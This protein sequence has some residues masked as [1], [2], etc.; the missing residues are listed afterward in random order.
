MSTDERARALMAD[1]RTSGRAAD[2]IESLIID[3]DRLYEERAELIRLY[4]GQVQNDGEYTLIDALTPA[5]S[6]GT[7]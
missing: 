7:T 6:G 3:R 1:L 2:A 4:R 5:N